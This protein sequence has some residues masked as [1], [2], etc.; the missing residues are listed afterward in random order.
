MLKIKKMSETIGRNVYTDTGDF[1]GQIEEVNLSDNRID[2]W[3][4]KVSGVMAQLIGGARGI[5]VPHQFVKA[6]GDIL[7]VNKSSLPIKEE[8]EMLEEPELEVAVSE[9]LV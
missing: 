9:N 2:G 8:G 7:I 4:I 6:I 1:L 5:I 3:R